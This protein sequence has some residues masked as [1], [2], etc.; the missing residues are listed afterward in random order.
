ML[1]IELRALLGLDASAA[2]TAFDLNFSLD[3]GMPCLVS[4]LFVYI[5]CILF[6]SNVSRN[7]V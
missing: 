4:L 3:A 7:S 2:P 1:M 5:A 6:Q